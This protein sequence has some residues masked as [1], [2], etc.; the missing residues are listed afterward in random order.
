MTLTYGSELSLTA[1]API[2]QASATPRGGRVTDCLFASLNPLRVEVA[3]VSRS[4]SGKGAAKPA[5]RKTGVKAKAPD[6][7]V[8]QVRLIGTDVAAFK[9]FIETTPLNFACAGPRV[10]A[11]GIA[12]AH[13]LMKRS[14][15][16]EAAKRGIVKVEI[17]AEFS[18]NRA[19]Q[20]AQIGK[21]NRFA[22]PNVL[23]T[24]RGVLLRKPS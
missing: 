21:G 1:A 3:M 20:A 18:A 11:E 9:Q 13:V 16:D 6:D 23:P 5:A 22:D 4:S 8:V 2:E 12:T 14:V 17:T 19:G 24:G 7:P 10:N 15:A